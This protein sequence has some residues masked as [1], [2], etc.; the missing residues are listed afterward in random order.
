MFD[1]FLLLTTALV[2]MAF[3]RSSRR[4][5]E[6]PRGYVWILAAIL[7]LT[8][9]G[10][11][12]ESR[13]VGIVAMGLTVLVVVVPWVLE[14]AARLF[15]A[16]GMLRLAVWSA[17]ARAML[18]LGAGLSRQQ[19]ILRGLA[20]LE[21]DGV[22]AAIGYFRGLAHETDDGGELA[23]IN[24][25]IVSMLLYGQR[26]DEGIRHYESRFHPR[27]AALRPAL[28]L[29]LMRA[30]GEVGA[31]E[32]A[33]ALLQALEDGPVGNDPRSLGLVSQARLTFLVYAG[34][35]GA[36]HDALGTTARQQ[37]GL[38]EASG[39]LFRGLAARQAG[40]AGRARSELEQVEDLA[41]RRDDRVV[42]SARRAMGELG[43]PPALLEP[44][45][46]AE[47]LVPY[48]EAVAAR[49][50]AFVRLAPAVKRSGTLIATP[51][52]LV[53]LGVGY[54]AMRWLDAG[55]LALLQVGASTP[56]MI[57]GDGW[58]R[59]WTGSWV[60]GDPLGLLLDLYT[61]WFS[62]PLVERMAGSGRVIVIA[63]LGSAV[64]VFVSAALGIQ[65]GMVLGGGGPAATALLGAAVALLFKPGD[66]G[67]RQ[68]ARRRLMVPLIMVAV[69]QGV[70][71]I[72]G[73][74]AVEA[75]WHGLLAAVVVGVLLAF[76]PTYP[77]S[78]RIESGVALLLSLACVLALVRAARESPLSLLADAPWTTFEVG[79]ASV[80]APRTFERIDE[81]QDVAGLPLPLHVGVLD[82]L[83][84]RAGHLVQVM[85]V[86]PD[87]DADLSAPGLL[88]LD[89]ALDAE[90]TLVPAELPDAFLQTAHKA[91]AHTVR[92]NG[93][94]L[95][96]TVER[97]LGP[98]PEDPSVVL[99][100]AS[101]ALE[102]QGALYARV[103]AEASLSLQ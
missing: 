85:V 91:E 96:V 11:A 22:D 49:L 13:F 40:D 100:A 73:F 86:V 101:E 97:R 92:R 44:V 69:V 29:G 36:V 3:L 66:G 88:R 98:A 17:G 20:V 70:S 59:I 31:L 42:E 18:M 93:T 46:I 2:G 15:F 16:R 54:F 58:W 65:L 61:I 56:E 94:E 38:S 90:L 80:P 1:E 35:E 87:H 99:F 95:G 10:V 63:L 72:P 7:G 57:R 4:A 9:I 71:A 28:V 83:A 14:A 5:E 26:W 68:S 76:I 21:R 41:G 74:L 55:G 43:A 84:L 8:L 78:R 47:E 64:G 62:A 24:E 32:R 60:H 45:S 50:G 34:A 51:A 82:G 30:Y 89:P 19:P 39:A 37:L 79:P 75:S 103:L 53:A 48:V 23:L 12:Q 77:W 67:V 52:I 6:S 27:Y 81:R 25:Q 102:R 33:A